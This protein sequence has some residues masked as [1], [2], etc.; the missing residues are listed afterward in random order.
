MPSSPEGGTL[1]GYG[2]PPV[3]RSGATDTALANGFTAVNGKPLSPR[4]TANSFSG[5]GAAYGSAPKPIDLTV[6]KMDA[7]LDAP[8]RS[9]DAMQVD[10]ATTASVSPAAAS[11]TPSLSRKRS[12]SP[13]EPATDQE[14][15]R[16]PPPP[17]PSTQGQPKPPPQASAQ[18][19]LP[20]ASAAQGG[21]WSAS[22]PQGISTLS[23]QSASYPP[24]DSESR[25]AWYGDRA[26]HS[27]SLS[28][29]EAQTAELLRSE[30]GMTPRSQYPSLSSNV[31]GGTP[32]NLMPPT[33][34]TTAAGVQVD[35]RK[36][37]RV[38]SSLA[39]RRR[40]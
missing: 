4:S 3:S 27:Q 18:S 21:G 11:S 8:P 35:P 14:D 36:R 33:I 5:P 31:H 37:K 6:P 12:L 38:C 7:Q 20:S 15:E 16:R 2:T 30:I 22:P 17:Q 26:R 40:R 24:Q 19:P 39:A 23:N 29:D 13:G 32:A 10:N 25:E 1:N 28:I 34:E 9:A